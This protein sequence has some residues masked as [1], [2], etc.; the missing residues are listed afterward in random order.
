VRRLAKKNE[1][2]NGYH[3]ATLVYDEKYYKPLWKTHLIDIKN[4]LRGD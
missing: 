4:Y 1:D 3:P 2:L